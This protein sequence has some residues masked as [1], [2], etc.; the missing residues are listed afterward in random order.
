LPVVTCRDPS[1][2]QAVVDGVGH[3]FYG[4]PLELLLYGHGAHALQR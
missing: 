3:A 4:S 1:L 2:N